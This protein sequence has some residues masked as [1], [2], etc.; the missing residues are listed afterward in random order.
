MQ[1]NEIYLKLD[2]KGTKGD[3]WMLSKAW[4]SLEEQETQTITAFVHHKSDVLFFQTDARVTS[5]Y[6]KSTPSQILVNAGSSR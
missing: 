6:I 2:I 5:G 3:F 4:H 1:E